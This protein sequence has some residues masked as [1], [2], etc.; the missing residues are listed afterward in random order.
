MHWGSGVLELSR[1]ES[2][3]VL[4][5]LPVAFVHIDRSRCH[6]TKLKWAAFLEQ[7]LR[8]QEGVSRECGGSCAGEVVED[9]G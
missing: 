5:G 9:E 4:S 7:D 8:Q 6:G 1:L 2:E 3:G